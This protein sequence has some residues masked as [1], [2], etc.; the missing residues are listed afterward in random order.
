MTAYLTADEIM[1]QVEYIA[2]IV[3]DT[4]E[5]ARQRLEDIADLVES[6]LGAEEPGEEE[7]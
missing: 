3:P 5:E 7:E 1:E 6:Y 4:L 2:R